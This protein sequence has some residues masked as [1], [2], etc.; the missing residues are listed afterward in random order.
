[1]IM[2]IR[3]LGLERKILL[4]VFIPLLGGLFPAGLILWR[5]QRDLA[6][7]SHLQSLA[8]LVWKLSDLEAKIDAEASNWYFF[9][10]SWTATDDE[11]K[12]ERAKQDQ[13]RLE[14]DQAVAD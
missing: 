11:K 3:G 7:M 9:K 4:L 12:I 5:A 10:P 13:W 8:R 2:S 14:T 1:M 6:E